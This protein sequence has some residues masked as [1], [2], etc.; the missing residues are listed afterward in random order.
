MLDLSEIAGA[1]RGLIHCL[2]ETGAKA[3]AVCR[4]MLLG[5]EVHWELGVP[6]GARAETHSLDAHD[7]EDKWIEQRK[8]S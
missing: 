6:G 5:Q 8:N 7:T 3:S 2:H 4:R 1:S